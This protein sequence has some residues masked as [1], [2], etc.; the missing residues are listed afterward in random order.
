MTLS[1]ST[2]MNGKPNQFVEK[3]LYGYWKHGLIGYDKASE[4]FDTPMSELKNLL[5]KPKIHTVR[6]DLLDRW[7]VGMLIHPVINNRTPDRKQFAITTP[8]TRVQNIILSLDK[9][10]DILIEI[11]SRELSYTER[12]QFAFNDGFDNWTDFVLYWQPFIENSEDNVYDGKLIH[13]TDIKY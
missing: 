6:L 11:D 8:C 2:T 13:W 3:I 7:K 5:I 4:I 10:K 1:F 12:I 9:D